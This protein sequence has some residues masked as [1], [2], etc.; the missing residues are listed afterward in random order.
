MFCFSQ[1][2]GQRAVKTTRMFRFCRFCRASRLRNTPQ[3]L[4]SWAREE[5]SWDNPL[6]HGGQG[7]LNSN[8]QEVYFFLSSSRL[9]S[10]PKAATGKAD[11]FQAKVES[12]KGE[13][14]KQLSMVSACF[15]ASTAAGRTTLSMGQASL[16]LLQGMVPLRLWMQ[17]TSVWV[18]GLLGLTSPLT[19]IF[20]LELLEWVSVLSCINATLLQLLLFIQSF[21][22]ASITFYLKY[23]K[24]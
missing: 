15:S 13:A 11:K 5:E 4:L 10:K 17:P 3:K 18:R 14:I 12:H 2:R 6:L 22:I 1:P 19:L 23:I 16:L 8:K 20:S 9:C 24:I 7:A 21:P